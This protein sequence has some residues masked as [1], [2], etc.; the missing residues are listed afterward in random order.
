MS[1]AAKLALGFDIGPK[2]GR[3]VVPLAK[4]QR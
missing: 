3:D 1:D 4:L 2:L